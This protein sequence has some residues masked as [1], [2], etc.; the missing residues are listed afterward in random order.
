METRDV[1]TDGFP[2][3]EAYFWAPKFGLL[4]GWPLIAGPDTRSPGRHLKNRRS[5][6][7]GFVTPEKAAENPEEVQWEASELAGEFSGVRYWVP[8]K[9]FEKAFS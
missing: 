2:A 5:R 7:Q 4:A 6:F 9:S 3:R 8:A 1:R